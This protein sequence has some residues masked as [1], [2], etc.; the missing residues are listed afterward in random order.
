[1]RE[2][3]T[4]PA[5]GPGPWD[6]SHPAYPRC[7][8]STDGIAGLVA[9][10]P[11]V[12]DRRSPARADPSPRTRVCTI[13]VSRSCTCAS[14]GSPSSAFHGGHRPGRCRQPGEPGFP[15]AC[16][17]VAATSCIPGCTPR[18]VGRASRCALPS[19]PQVTPSKRGSAGP[20]LPPMFAGRRSGGY[21]P[22]RI[23]VAPALIASDAT[24]AAC[25]TPGPRCSMSA[26]VASGTRRPAVTSSA[27]SSLRSSATACDS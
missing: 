17:S 23:A 1:M 26:P 8:A 19:D 3:S 11:P 10:Q 6:G 15:P 22:A 24:R 14:T 16:A 4:A 2:M 9:A 20:V 21:A 25:R 5:S 13:A 12:R 27:P 7:P 18:P